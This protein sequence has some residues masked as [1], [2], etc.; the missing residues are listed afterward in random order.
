MRG[1]TT[2]VVQFVLTG[3]DAN[4]VKHL[5]LVDPEGV[6]SNSVKWTSDLRLMAY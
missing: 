5:L 4:V 1:S 3:M 2:Q 6:V